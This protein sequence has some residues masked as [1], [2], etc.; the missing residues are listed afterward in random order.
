MALVFKDIHWL[1]VTGG[2]SSARRVLEYFYSSPFYDKTSDNEALRLQGVMNVEFD[3]L[4]G[5][6][7]IQYI[8]DEMIKNPY[9]SNTFIYVVK[10]IRRNSAKN[11][12]VL[13]IYYC[14]EGEIYK[15][16][17]FYGLIK[18]RYQAT[19][20]EIKNSFN[21]LTATI[22]NTTDSIMMF[23]S[24][25]TFTRQK[26]LHREHTR[27]YNN[28]MSQFPGMSGIYTDLDRSLRDQEKNGWSTFR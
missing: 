20:H 10:K 13:D 24:E 2:L 7:G 25:K 12:D 26:S 22:Q 4:L 1:N 28:V 6:R 19:A 8:C 27:R 23:S 18:T 5:L 16:P 14:L 17:D 21:S 9:D 15:V 3:Y 11:Y